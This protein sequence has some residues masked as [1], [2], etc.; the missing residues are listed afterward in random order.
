[1]ERLKFTFATIILLTVVTIA[2]GL[3][4]EVVS[5]SP[6]AVSFVTV[7]STP[8]LTNSPLSRP[9]TDT[10]TPTLTHSPSPTPT[11]TP[12]ATHTP[13]PT[14]TPTSTATN[15]PTATATHTPTATNTPT[16]TATPTTTS[17]RLVI[18][19]D[20]SMARDIFIDR[21][22]AVRLL[23]GDS[24][25]ISIEKGGHIIDD[26]VADRTPPC[27]KEGEQF[28][29]FYEDPSYTY[30][31]ADDVTLI[32]QNY[33][34]E[35]QDI[36][37]NGEAKLRVQ[38]SSNASIEIPQGEY[39]WDS[40][41]P[42][43]SPPCGDVGEQIATIL[44]DPYYITINP[45]PSS[46]TLPVIDWDGDGIFPPDD[47]CPYDPETFNNVFDTDGCSDTQQDLIDLVVRD[48]DDF[49]RRDAQTHGW[50]YSTPSVQP[51][52]I[53]TVCSG[54]LIADNIA[55]FCIDENKIYFERV[56]L[57]SDLLKNDEYG[58]FAIAMTLGH[59]WGH[60]IQKQLNLAYDY[61][62]SELQ[63]DCF[64]G[65]YGR[66]ILDG[67]SDFL[68]LE[69][70]DLEEGARWF[71]ALGLFGDPTTHGTSNERFAAYLLGLL[72]GVD[73]CF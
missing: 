69:E 62:D 3:Q 8:M 41:Y 11:G 72:D 60:S 28:A 7:T 33:F 5:L 57:V 20:A 32:V 48:L 70:G 14:D 4:P 73:G 10:P 71:F 64:A 25:T 61:P 17:I 46:S 50:S 31:S 2:C 1:M 58:D 43:T 24:Q 56:L 15:T 55:F 51:Y 52:N 36:F 66:Y 65:A 49:W 16:S 9:E 59:E 18:R 54:H 22:F 39:R 29:N 34:S 38:P 37:L 47:L 67:Q 19:N 35:V 27:G 53:L 45:S 68:S 23:P 21:R 12:T 40:C 30:T 26:C 44:D 6:P 13:R 63:A 42:G